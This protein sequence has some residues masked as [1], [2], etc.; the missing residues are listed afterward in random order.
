MAP[1]LVHLLL[2]AA[3]ADRPEWPAGVVFL[4]PFRDIAPRP[5]ERPSTH[6]ERKVVTRLHRMT[7]VAARHLDLIA[8]AW[9]K[10]TT[11]VVGGRENKCA[12]G[13]STAQRSAQALG[14]N[15]L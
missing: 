1:K 8:V 3:Y 11:F 13:R 6:E 9:G 4:G 12:I 2:R 5:G 15:L 14:N 7:T 10:A